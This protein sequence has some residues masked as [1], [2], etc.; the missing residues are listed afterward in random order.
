MP[1]SPKP[2]DVASQIA[3]RTDPSHSPTDRPS[4]PKNADAQKNQHNPYAVHPV[5][6]EHSNLTLTL[7]YFA[8]SR[9]SYS[10]L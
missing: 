4:L 3:G 7:A 8:Y 1:P 6:R 2:P 5:S 9:I 10:C